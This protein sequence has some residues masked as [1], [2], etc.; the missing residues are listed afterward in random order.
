MLQS[1]IFKCC[2]RVIHMLQKGSS[3]IL[4][5]FLL[6]HQIV[7]IVESMI[8]ECCNSVIHMLQKGSSNV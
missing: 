8:F 4:R 2:N 3:N 5:F 7:L 1:L 6:L